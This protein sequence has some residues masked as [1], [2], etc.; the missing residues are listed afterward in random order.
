MVTE[1]VDPKYVL[2]KNGRKMLR[3]TCSSCGITKT[4][5]VKNIEG[6]NIDIHKALLSLLPKKGLTLPGYKY[7]GLGNPLDSGEPSNEVD[8]VCKDHDICYD[9][10]PSNKS[11][12]DKNMLTG[13][14]S[15]KSK[16]IGEKIAKNL[17]V[18]PVISAKYKLGL[19]N[20]KNEKRR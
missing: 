10:N 16:T 11:M 17:I 2:A 15:S 14:K 1:N 4:K 18:K 3:A 13:L 12:C 5:F 7:C 19:G 20:S 6:G 9:E 8:A